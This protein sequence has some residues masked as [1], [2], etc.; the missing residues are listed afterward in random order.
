MKK[1]ISI[2]LVLVIALSLCACGENNNSES[3]FVGTYKRVGGMGLPTTVGYNGGTL[4]TTGDFD[5]EFTIEINEDGTGTERCIAYKYNGE[6]NAVVYEY[7]FAWEVVDEYLYITGKYTNNMNNKQ[8]D[9]NDRYRLEG[10]TL[11]DADNSNFTYT[12]Q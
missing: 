8:V 4:H 1:A 11:V 12:K 10:K 6:T 2:L 5:C 7:D 9:V 3:K